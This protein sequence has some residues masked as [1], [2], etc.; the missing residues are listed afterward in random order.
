MGE[1]VPCKL[2]MA[3]SMNDL[4]DRVKDIPDAAPK[5]LVKSAQKILTE[6]QL[7]DRSRD[8]E[9]A[10]ILFMRYFSIV[11]AIQKHQDYKNSKRYYDGLLD[12]KMTMKVIDRA[13][14]LKKSLERRYENKSSALILKKQ[15]EEKK[16]TEK[17]QQAEK[18][19]LAKK[20]TE[21]SKTPSSP[22][23]N[24]LLAEEGCI[25]CKKLYSLIKERCSSYLILDSRPRDDFFESQMKVSNVI[26]IPEEILKP[27]LTAGRIS[28]ELDDSARNVWVTLRHKVDFLILV[29]W[30]TEQPPLPAPLRC[31]IDAMVKWDP[32]KEYKSQP[33]VLQGG[34]DMWRLMYPMHTTNPR[35]E[36]RAS[37][38]TPKIDQD[39]LNF[40]YP[41]L[42]NAFLVTPS[43]SPHGKPQTVPGKTPGPTPTV[44]RELKPSNLDKEMMMDGKNNNDAYVS[45]NQVFNN[46]AKPEDSPIKA[47]IGSNVNTWET[48]DSNKSLDVQRGRQT[49][50]DKIDS[51]PSIPSRALKPKELLESLRRKQEE[52]E[53]EQVLLE[54]SV[55]VEQD[56]LKKIEEME[57]TATALE[58]TQDEESRKLLKQTEDRL[59]EEIKKLQIKSTEMETQYNKVHKQNE[60]LWKMV[61]LALS[62]QLGNLNL[63][64]SP[65]PEQ[66]T[67][68]L[69]QKQE[70]E[71]LRKQEDKRKALQDQIE[72]MRKERKDKERLREQLENEKKAREKAEMERRQAEERKARIESEMRSHRPKGS[73]GD[74][75]TTKLRS[76]PRSSPVRGG[77]N[78]KR[79]HS[80]FNLSQ[81]GEDDD[82]SL[83][84][85]N[86]PSFDRGLKPLN[87]PQR[88]NINAARQRNFEPKY[89][90]VGQARTGLKNLG[91][92]CYMNS[93]LQCLNNTTPFV[94]YFIEGTYSDDINPTSK[95]RGE[96]AEEFGAV[97]R[98]LWC[99]QYRSIAMWDL[100]TTVGRYHKPF[101]GYDQHD[102]HEF[103]IKLMDWVH[104]D[105]NKITGK[106]PPMKEQNHDN[107]PDYVAAE[108]VMEE[109]RRRDQSIVQTLF[110]GL[111]RSTIECSV[112]GHRSLTFEPFSIISLSFPSH[113]RCSLKD[114]FHHFYKETNLE[115]KCCKCKK[116]RNCLRKLDIWKLPPIL[117]LH[118]NRFEHDVLMKKTQS[119]VDFPLEN[120]DLTKYVAATNR[121]TNFDLYGVS[122]HYGTM[123]GGHYTGFC[124]S[125]ITKTWY[126]FDD[127]EVYELSRESVRSSAAYIL[128]YEAS[129]MSIKVNSLI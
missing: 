72:R 65:K 44:V 128:F 14:E 124:K 114:M 38:T 91:N 15:E 66:I 45:N 103:L 57:E 125:S 119:Y 102:S 116:M 63:G 54:E 69:R 112:C 92:T 90:N 3:K 77:S 50:A 122:N 56:T 59:Q 53:E 23:S 96:V 2:H 80:A 87:T 115:Y 48:K 70:Q 86:M 32:G 97:I 106:K 11:K 110:H 28:S 49:P 30:V 55:K 84:G 127:H 8:E 47:A 21:A 12:P 17:S 74:T 31:L 1:K 95:F 24:G 26:N 6:A 27:G 33:W 111:H 98:A 43:P 62:G 129:N 18:E 67:E 94:K 105:L 100:K 107:L 37:A 61:N 75:Y 9:K 42:D 99:G 58:K 68:A 41:D 88:R 108:K 118:L 101:Q 39:S 123:D 19:K 82:K 40:E 34:Y 52:M 51:L 25:S 104:E 36:R 5:L 4:N 117:I 79:S 93:I 113:G 71:Q 13:E 109:I 78:L 73:T 16:A 20:I 35:V 46:L 126:K 29:D 81:L 121:Y 83:T 64:T 10:Y 120:M 7:V 76:S 85:S 60:E 22:T 89:G